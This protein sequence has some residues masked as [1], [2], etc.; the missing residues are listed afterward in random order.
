SGRDCHVVNVSTNGAV[1]GGPNAGTNRM[2]LGDGEPH[3]GAMY[4][5]FATKHALIGISEM[6]AR[7]LSGTH[8][9]VPV[10]CAA[11]H[12]GTGIFENS[13]R[14][15]PESA[16][17]PMTAEEIDATFGRMEHDRGR[18]YGDREA[19]LPEECAARLVRAI[20]ENHVYV[21]THPE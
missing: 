2:R 4:G 15:R 21:F 17:G 6:L 11:R 16:G 20:R 1:I 5:Y 7:D 19:R 12:P 14:Y 3:K 18:T 8:V 9:G 10:P 13:A